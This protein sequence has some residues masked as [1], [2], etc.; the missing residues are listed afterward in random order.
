MRKVEF[1]PFALGIEADIFAIKYS[2]EKE[3]EVRKFLIMYKDVEL[4]KVKNDFK[5]IYLTLENILTKGALESY[6]RNEGK[7]EDRV[8]AIPVFS[9]RLG[10]NTNRGTLRLYCIRVSEKLLILGG[11]G[12]KFTRTYQEDNTLKFHVESLQSIDR[13]LR[14]LEHLG[15]ELET[16]LC[17]LNLEI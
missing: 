14:E 9:S 11:G 13:K 5:T 10:R 3:T 12:E 2:D 6:F 7:M 4:L 17:N 1:E 16:E 15:V 8:C